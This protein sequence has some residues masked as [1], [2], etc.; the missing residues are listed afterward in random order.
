[1]K[2]SRKPLR[3]NKSIIL[4]LLVSL[5]LSF[6]SQGCSFSSAKKET[7]D[8][9]YFD[10]IISITL[11]GNT[12]E[13]ERLFKGCFELAEKYEN[14]FS[15]EIKTSDISRV[16]N[17]SGSP[18][19]VDVE[20]LQLVEKGLNYEEISGGLFS[21]TCGSLT[22]LW[23]VSGRAKDPDLLS[24]L[25]SDN[26]I[27]AALSSIGGE[28]LAIDPKKCEITLL[29]KNTKLDLGGIAKGYIADRMKEYLL[30]NGCKNAIINLGG[31]VLCLGK[32]PDNNAFIVGIQKPFSENGDAAFTLSIDSL[33]VVTSG[34]YQRYF[35]KDGIL[36]HHI[37]DLS[38]GYPAKS[39]LDSVTIV[40]ESS[41]DGDALSTICFILGRE[42]SIQFLS[43]LREKDPESPLDAVF[44]DTEGNI[45]FTEGLSDI[46][47]IR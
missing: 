44:I 29:D 18:V 9:F 23:N 36:Y 41:V 21:I 46:I 33:S 35:E 7:K 34:D 13:N 27:S 12:S 8:G 15:T 16:N 14:L 31:N 40:S 37:M 17:S 26:E 20:T 47:D 28:K 6:M 1:M 42:N 24:P 4:F 19:I 45:F 38:T 5:T 25:P 3:S 10:T 11:Y 43:S 39:D 30:S 2:K 32:R 22:E